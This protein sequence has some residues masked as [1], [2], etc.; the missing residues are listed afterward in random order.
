MKK[1]LVI[2]FVLVLGL[3]VLASAQSFSCT[4]DWEVTFEYFPFLHNDGCQHFNNEIFALSST[5]EVDLASAGWLFS[6]VSGFDSGLGFNSQVFSAAGCLGA[7]S[8]SAEMEFLPNAVT[9]QTQ[10]WWTDYL[11][12]ID[13]PGEIIN[14]FA[15]LYN[16]PG[17]ACDDDG[18]GDTMCKVTVLN[19]LNGC[20]FSVW[21]DEETG[22]A[23]KDFEFTAAVNLAGMNL[24]GL[25][26]MNAWAGTAKEKDVFLWDVCTEAEF[27][28]DG[29]LV[30]WD[31][32]EVPDNLYWAH[33]VQSGPDLISPD[34]SYWGTA[35]SGG[36][37]PTGTGSRF[38]L[39]GAAGGMDFTSYTYFNLTESDA[40]ADTD[41]GCPV[42][43]KA[44][45]YAVAGG[46]GFAFTEEYFM[47]EGIP[48]CCDTTIDAALKLVCPAVTTSLTC[49]CDDDKYKE[50]TIGAVPYT[51]YFPKA[52]VCT[53]TTKTVGFEYLQ[54]LVKDIP[55]IPGFYDL[56]ASVKLTTGDKE[57]SLCGQPSFGLDTCFSMTLLANW[58]EDKAHNSI[59]N[60]F[61]GI[62]IKDLSFTCECAP[63]V[64]VTFT[65]V[66]YDLETNA[67]KSLAST[68]NVIR[69][70]VPLDADSVDPGIG[71][72]VD[73]VLRTD[74]CPPVVPDTDGYDDILVEYW[75]TPKYKYYAWE[76]LSIEL[77]GDACCGGMF[78]ITID[79]Y[80][81]KKY[82][83]DP[84]FCGCICDTGEDKVYYVEDEETRVKT[85]YNTDVY[86]CTWSKDPNY[87]EIGPLNSLFSWMATDVS[88]T[89]GLFSNFDI[90]II[91]EVSFRGWEK[92]GLTFGFTW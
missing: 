71:D 35:T 89:L 8:L 47:V 59:A 81:G 74:P 92:F 38:T 75:D 51:I 30:Y 26:F 12:F 23:F 5:L 19:L 70:L 91:S 64:V 88:V 73:P 43:G 24:E 40:A 84:K 57:F 76:S 41:S 3:G 52:G 80:I 32:V 29:D 15:Y 58:E 33:V 56:T 69:F 49:V 21:F 31:L 13:P 67:L 11:W 61:T 62:D 65:D 90:T 79:N 83:A 68:D 85:Y 82:E 50:I 46:C 28:I 1:A 87:T 14:S 77:D 34:V 60:K 37:D 9:K 72:L 17:D 10:W 4:G 39:S 78:A 44:G 6:S 86:K 36:D 55:F 66:L 18:V 7:V 48:L 27:S 63:G 22:P 53:S 25:F 20:P 54:F 2:A 45:D 16:N 42:L